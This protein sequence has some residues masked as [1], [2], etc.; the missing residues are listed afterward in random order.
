METGRGQTESEDG[1]K[2]GFPSDIV[3]LC[4]KIS[5]DALMALPDDEFMRVY[6]GLQ[7]A[8]IVVVPT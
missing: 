5:Y 8:P 7:D 4:N 6:D 1:V 2:I 3:D